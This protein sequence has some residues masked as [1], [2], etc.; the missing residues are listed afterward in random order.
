[1]WTQYL[2]LFYLIFCHLAAISHG[3]AF[4]LWLINERRTVIKYKSYIFGWS[5]WGAISAGGFALLA[6][7][8][9]ALSVS[10]QQTS[11]QCKGVAAKN[12]RQHCSENY[13]SVPMKH[14]RTQNYT[15]DNH[16]SFTARKSQD[17]RTRVQNPVNHY[18]I[19][20][21]T[22]RTQNQGD[23]QE[24]PSCMEKN[25]SSRESVAAPVEK[26]NLNTYHTIV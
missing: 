23:Y 25:C 1:M 2:L 8:I 6:S 15:M 17:Y 5:F 13:H 18:G 10:P 26:T 24:I 19:T 3:T 16:H 9:S 22:L 14:V 7:V 12:T 4:I 20:M 11:K 21:D